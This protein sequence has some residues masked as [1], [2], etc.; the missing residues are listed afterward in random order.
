M[1][2]GLQSNVG[3]LVVIVRSVLGCFWERRE[4]K[5]NRVIVVIENEKEIHQVDGYTSGHTEHRSDMKKCNPYMISGASS[6]RGDS[7]SDGPATLSSS[8]SLSHFGR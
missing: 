5:P 7:S 6:L 2:R 4:P 1:Y 3:L 8:S